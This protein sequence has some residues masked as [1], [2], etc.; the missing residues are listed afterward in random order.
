MPSTTGKK[1]VIDVL[2]RK[3]KDDHSTIHLQ[4]QPVDKKEGSTKCRSQCLIC[5]TVF[6]NSDET[7]QEHLR[8]KRH[9][10][11]ERM[12]G[13][14]EVMGQHLAFGGQQHR[15][16]VFDTHGSCTQRAIC[17]S[18]VRSMPLGLFLAQWGQE[19]TILNPLSRVSSHLSALN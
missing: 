2:G 5:N 18:F 14:V 8:S 15:E 4:L 17:R 7:V 3:F 6:N 1:G 12:Q 19:G 10:C 13:E 9:Q 16:A 11:M